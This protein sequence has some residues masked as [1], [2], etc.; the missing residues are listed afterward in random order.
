[1]S[2]QNEPGSV[3]YTASLTDGWRVLRCA[4]PQTP[5]CVCGTAGPQAESY[6][7]S[8]WQTVCL[9]HDLTAAEP[10]APQNDPQ[11]GYLPRLG[12][13]Y[14]RWFRLD[15]AL[16][17]RRIRLRFPD[18]SGQ[19]RVYVNGC[20]QAVNYGSHAPFDVDI[21][22][23][24]RFGPQPNL[25]AVWSDNFEPE[26]QWYS[27]T[28]ILQ[29]VLLCA[30]ERVCID[31]G[32]L[33][34]RTVRG[35]KDLWQIEVSA[36]VTEPDEPELWIKAELFAPDGAGTACFRLEK[37]A[38]QHLR[39]SCGVR[40][41]VLW[42]V[43]AGSLYAL[44]LTLFRGQ[45]ALDTLQIS[46]GFRE[47]AFSPERGLVLNGRQMPLRGFCFHDDQGNYGAALPP[48]VYTHQL[49]QMLE[50]GANVYRVMGHGPSETLLEQCDRYG[51]L[52]IADLPRF[53]CGQI[54]L[55]QTQALLR[56]V[57][58]HPCA[59]AY[60][61]NDRA[62]VG[63][64]SLRTMERLRRLV[65]E[66]DGDRPLC[67]ELTRD[68]T[69]DGAAAAAELLA[70]ADAGQLDM[71][72][73]A[74]PEKPLLLSQTGAISDLLIQTQTDTPYAELAWE[75]L[76][77][78]E[79]RPFVCGTLARTGAE[80][81]GETRNLTFFSDSASL[82]CVGTKKDGFYAYLAH[83]SERPVLHLCGHWSSRRPAEPVRVRAYTNL[84]QVRFYVNGQLRAQVRRGAQPWVDA[85]L[86]YEPGEL[87]AVGLRAQTEAAEDTLLTAGE[88]A[89]LRLEPQ[90]RTLPADGRSI[91]TVEVTVVDAQGRRVP[92]GSQLF[93]A[94]A[95]PLLRVRF[96][97]NADPYCPMFPEPETSCLYQGRGIVVLQSGRQSGDA[98]VTVR[99][100]GLPEVSCGITLEPAQSLPE[101]PAVD[102]LYL[103]GWFI[104]HV[105]RQEP[106]IF[107]YTADT[108]YIF[109]QPDPEPRSGQQMEHPFYF[110]TGYVICC[111]EPDAPAFGDGQQCAI[112]F[113]RLRGSAKILI[114]ARTYT[115]VF[116]QEFYH[117]KT[118]PDEMP[119][120][121][122]LPGVRGGD[123]LVI[124]VLIQSGCGATGALGPVRFEI[125]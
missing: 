28:G 109:W 63:A 87:R 78:A 26:F 67:A 125:E 100:P 122:P 29:P 4:Q 96:S 92:T 97:D 75:Q 27:G 11:N 20:L 53:D 31:G 107:Q 5:P 41:P 36:G 38:G 114:R 113:E 110:R 121:L 88:P 102:G 123:R 117:E 51:V 98:L 12:V 48:E 86:A 59:A 17:G 16:E 58:N 47:A 79:Q 15:R 13:W 76:R 54:A 3:R 49:Q 115:N 35:D 99:S 124:K 10:P 85:C 42:Q 33:R 46:A 45:T 39:G 94:E 120:R 118:S 7:D 52:L 82:S 69:A 101:L 19:S 83:W 84:E 71:L 74:F 60:L 119:L 24:A 95:S 61:V 37:T 56:R 66:L 89:A 73:R 55:E 116:T 1:M 8:A 43:G 6:D 77:M 9:P 91:L 32:S 23:L 80:F 30:S 72:H 93:T 2:L 14:R 18:V 22:E 25:I 44:Q 70:A 57:R 40:S 81:R 103:N 21:T 50:M 108:H 105:W 34:L 90:C 112:V 68:L 62:E 65:Q 104:S 106:D 64:Q 111:N